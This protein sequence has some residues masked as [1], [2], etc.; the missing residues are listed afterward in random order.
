MALPAPPTPPKG[1]PAGARFSGTRPTGNWRGIGGGWWAPAKAVAPAKPAPAKPAASPYNNPLYQPLQQ[2]SGKPLAQAT[3]ALT[4]VQ[5][6]PLISQ[7]TQQ[8]AQNTK[9]GAAA[10]KT[11]AGY[12]NQLGQYAQRSAQDVQTAA[13]GLNTQLQN[14]G[15]GTQ[16]ALD[17]FGQRA[18]TP[19]LE[20]LS[21][22]GLAAGA[23]A[24][25]AAALASQRSLAAQ[26]AAANE[27]FGAKVGSS[28]ATLA[29]QNLGAY[30]LRGQERLGEIA[31]A[32][33][34]AQQPVQ[35]KLAT[36]RATKAAAY[37]TNLAAA[38]QQERNYAVVRAGLGLKQAAIT[39]A[40]QR[41]A[42]AQAAATR[43][44]QMAQ[45]GATQRTRMNIDARSVQG[46]LDRQTRLQIAAEN[47]ATR[48]ALAAGR[49]SAKGGNALSSA[50]QR[51]IWNEITRTQG[52]VRWL[53]SY[54]STHRPDLSQ[55]QVFNQTY[56]ALKTGQMLIP[57]DH[58]LHPTLRDGTTPNPAYH[59]WHYVN[60]PKGAIGDVPLLNVAYN[61]LYQ[62]LRPAD[63]SYLHSVGFT[64]GNLMPIYQNTPYKPPTT[65]G[66]R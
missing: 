66:Y 51:V 16:T 28:A 61:S 7:L 17:Q 14:I 15:Q 12:F 18:V 2:L 53:H 34:L 38:R 9:Q 20:S 26:N 41:A 57:P 32:T 65:G 58:S 63:V 6:D 44:T 54:L 36:T 49:A 42:A 27:A 11:T 35:V 40:N 56:Q 4:N 59:N 46:N 47:N 55:T 13:Q 52:R 3:Q 29:A 22:Q 8:I 30:A 43:R 48:R 10:Q 33:R 21:A 5:Y 25:L 1:A 64:I 23:P 39:A 45:S 24:Q 60:I 19:G 62:G 37:A 31:Q 50:G